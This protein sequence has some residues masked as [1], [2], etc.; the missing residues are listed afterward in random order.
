MGCRNSELT[1]IACPSQNPGYFFTHC[2]Y[3]TATAQ[4]SVAVARVIP[5]LWPGVVYISELGSVQTNVVIESEFRVG[6]IW[7]ANFCLHFICYSTVEEMNSLFHPKMVGCVVAN[8]TDR[9]IIKKIFRRIALQTHTPH[10]PASASGY[11]EYRKVDHFTLHLIVI[12]EH[13][14]ETFRSLAI[15]PACPFQLDDNF[16]CG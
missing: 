16:N 15:R 2:T 1:E 3:L 5:S 11:L 4:G 12:I 13:G 8:E 10:R 7:M 14:G 9:A 6:G